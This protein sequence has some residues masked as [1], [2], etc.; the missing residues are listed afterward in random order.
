M[1]GHLPAITTVTAHEQQRPLDHDMP[2]V[3][4]LEAPVQRRKVLGGAISESTT[5]PHKQLH[6]PAGQTTRDEFGAVQLDDPGLERV[7]ADLKIMSTEK[8]A[9]VLEGDRNIGIDF[10]QKT[11]IGPTSSV[12][13]LAL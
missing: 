3:M 8:P 5:G 4:P 10:R 1:H 2:V 13:L 11:A 7:A 6:E 12:F 9:A